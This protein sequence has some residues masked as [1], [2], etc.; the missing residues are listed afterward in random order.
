MPDLAPNPLQPLVTQI[1][2]L[3]CRIEELLLKIGNGG[4][5]GTT[6]TVII[7]EDKA[8]V[9][10]AR[11]M[12]VG[13]QPLMIVSANPNRISFS[14]YNVGPATVYLGVGKNVTHGSGAQPGF[15]LVVG[16]TAY[17]ERYLGEVYAVVQAGTAAIS[18]WE[19]VK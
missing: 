16:G 5:N 7:K 10:E 15:T 19:D 14:I 2:R 13:T 6:T 17:D 3:A 9:A 8:S 18:V 12:T 4:D 1:T 11:Q